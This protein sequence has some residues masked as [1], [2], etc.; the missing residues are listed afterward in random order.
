MSTQK[1]PDLLP[2]MLAVLR[3]PLDCQFLVDSV[4]PGAWHA[5]VPMG[6]VYANAVALIIEAADAQNWLRELVQRLADEFPARPEFPAVLDE[7][8]RTHRLGTVDDALAGVPPAELPDFSNAN[9]QQLRLLR[10]AFVETT[11]ASALDIL[12][13]DTRDQRLANLVAPGAFQQQVFDLLQLARKERWLNDLVRAALVEWPDAPELRRVVQTF[14]LT[15]TAPGS[16]SSEQREPS[17]TGAAESQLERII[18]RESGY[19]EPIVWLDALAD[20][21]DRVCR[22]EAGTHGFGTGCLVGPDLVLTCQHNLIGVGSGADLVMRFDFAL[23]GA[24]VRQGTTY[25][26]AAADWIVAS[27]PRDAGEG[28]NFALIRLAKAAGHEQMPDGQSRGWISINKQPAKSAVGE[29][30]V[31]LHHP[32]AGPMKMSLGVLASGD[33]KRLRHSATTEPGSSGGGCFSMALELIGLHEGKLDP[34]QFQ[35]NVA[36]RIE[37]I[38]QRIQQQCPGLLDAQEA[39]LTSSSPPKDEPYTNVALFCTN[40]RERL[41]KELPTDLVLDQDYK[42]TLPRKRREGSYSF[43][44]TRHPFNTGY[45]TSAAVYYYEIE[46]GKTGTEALVDCTLKLVWHREGVKNMYG[47]GVIERVPAYVKKVAAFLESNSYPGLLVEKDEPEGNIVVSTYRRYSLQEVDLRDA[48]ATFK[49]IVE[50]LEP[51]LREIYATDAL[52]LAR[53]A[54]S[55]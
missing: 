10:I 12:L 11:T 50:Q 32:I 20:M 3:T 9:G 46:I 14:S 51:K 53:R 38:A 4:R 34:T 21:R 13:S 5:I 33:G 39:V 16:R 26:V 7:I 52:S 40:I 55:K 1:H 48:V 47:K 37:A 2:L 31:V 23:A 30:V 25:A 54:R 49:N 24:S 36:V 43:W 15:A 42:A 27:E 45:D 29:T 35:Q 41:N 22:V 8:D 6:V 18:G 28:L 44:N 17:G 19:L